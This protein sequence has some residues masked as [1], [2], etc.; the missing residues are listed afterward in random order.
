[1]G[2]YAPREYLRLLEPIGIYTDNT[3]KHLSFFKGADKRIEDLFLENQI[4]TGDFLVCISPSAGNKIKQWYTERFA[5]V[6]DYIYKN[7]KA[8]IFVIGAK[9]DRAEVLGMMERLNKETKVINTLDILNLDELK[10]LI[11]KI[12]MFI[13]VDTGPIYIAEAFGVPTVDITGPIDEREQPPM[14][15]LNR[16]VNIKNRK[17]PELYV[18]NAKMY[19][20]VE[21]RRQT[22]E[23]TT[24]MVT[25][26]IDNL[27][28][29]INKNEHKV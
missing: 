16:I 27:C 2:S 21:A 19:N 5:E 9:N 22:E 6:A 11:S 26:E 25:D 29:F 10:A 3:K 12:N 17:R 18:M 24:K 8:K 28:D 7:Y 20:E 1:M 14:G 13:S 23:I 15:K 4:T